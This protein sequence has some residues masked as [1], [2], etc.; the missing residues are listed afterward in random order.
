MTEKENNAPAAA[1]NGEAE[2]EANID[3]G[4]RWLL[5]QAFDVIRE[6]YH[7]RAKTGERTAYIKALRGVLQIFGLY[8]GKYHLYALHPDTDE[9]LDDFVTHLNDLNASVVHPIF[10]TVRSKAL[11]TTQW[12]KRGSVVCVTELF[13]AA[14][15]EYKDAAQHAILFHDYNGIVSE[16][17][18]LSWRKEFERGRVKNRKATETYKRHMERLQNSPSEEIKKDAKEL[19]ECIPLIP[20]HNATRLSR[21]RIK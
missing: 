17:E 13:H 14:D 7:N 10:R 12:M 3:E 18:V 9:W 16:E 15:M 2:I 20:H 5:D 21:F 19:L 1:G 4:F 11:P 8:S 6:A